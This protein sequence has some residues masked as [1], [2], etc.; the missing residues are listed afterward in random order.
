MTA[1]TGNNN[2]NRKEISQRVGFVC[3]VCFNDADE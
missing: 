2:G 3:H 1:E